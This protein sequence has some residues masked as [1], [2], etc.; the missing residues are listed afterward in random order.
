MRAVLIISLLSLISCTSSKDK[1]LEDA[2]GLRKISSKEEFADLLTPTD[3][4]GVFE[5]DSKDVDKLYQEKSAL[6]QADSIMDSEIK[7]PKETEFYSYQIKK[8]DTALMIAFQKYRDLE[9][10]KNI[11]EW[12]PETSFKAGSVIRLRRIDEST[13]PEINTNGTPY[14]V[15]KDDFLIKIADKVYDGKKDYWV[16]IWKNNKIL[17]QDKDLIY[18]GF[19]LYYR[20]YQIAKKES[21]E[22]YQ[23]LVRMEQSLK[24]SKLTGF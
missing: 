3:E 9:M 13:L 5:F 11:L 16:S 18:P 14:I 7:L 15:N 1:N 8:G 21:N 10:W 19:V 17:V 4:E 22:Y 24:R 20:D 2:L 6:A 12:N 23:Q